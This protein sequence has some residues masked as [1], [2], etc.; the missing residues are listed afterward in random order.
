MYL[1]DYESQEAHTLLVS[2]VL[3]EVKQSLRAVLVRSF[4]Y[5]AIISQSSKISYNL[6][7]FFQNYSKTK[8][9][10]SIITLSI[11]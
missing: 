7:M 9:L 10:F 11:S 2:F 5:R 3:G 6:L 4:N 1:K 8:G